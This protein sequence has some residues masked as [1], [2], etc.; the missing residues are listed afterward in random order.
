MATLKRTQDRLIQCPQEVDEVSTALSLQ[1][2]PVDSFNLGTLM[3]REARFHRLPP[4]AIHR[5]L[6]PTT[7]GLQK[8]LLINRTPRS[9][10]RCTGS[11][12][13]IFRE[14]LSALAPRVRLGTTHQLQGL[15]I[16]GKLQRHGPI[17]LFHHLHCGLQVIF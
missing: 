10:L 8:S 13:Q 11:R 2:S 12:S 4:S 6:Y 16:I 15:A 3:P 17:F 9:P 14:S 7:S 5:R 1:G